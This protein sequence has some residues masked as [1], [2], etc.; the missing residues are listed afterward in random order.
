[1]RHQNRLARWKTENETLVST[2]TR[3]VRKHLEHR[4]TPANL[5]IAG[6]VAKGLTNLTGVFLRADNA[7]RRNVAGWDQTIDAENNDDNK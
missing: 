7:S 2:A 3:I 1:M 4:A 6:E 5:H